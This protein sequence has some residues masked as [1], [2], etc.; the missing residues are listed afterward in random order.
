MGKVHWG[1]ENTFEHFG[2]TGFD[3][4]GFLPGVDVRED[5]FDFGF[6]DNA[7]TRSE[8]AVLDQLP[9]M[10]HANS[11]ENSA[12]LT[13]QRIFVARC[14][15]TPV[16]AEIV[17]SQLAFQRDEKEIVITAANGSVRR[18]VNRFAW[19]DRIELVREPCLFSL[20]VVTRP[21][22]ADG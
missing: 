19:D 16:I 6:N 12:P 1:M 13:K 22:P 15:E 11:A 2:R 5:N 9:R 10:I 21:E 20:L 8:A 17:D 3:A 7:R 18:S 4:L 14:N